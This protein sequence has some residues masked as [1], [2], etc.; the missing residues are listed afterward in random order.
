VHC[1]FLSDKLKVLAEDT[2][3]NMSLGA[4]L[5]RLGLLAAATPNPSPHDQSSKVAASRSESNDMHVKKLLGLPSKFEIDVT[6]AGKQAL[7]IRVNHCITKLICV[8]SLVPNILDSEN[9]A[10]LMAIL[11]PH[12]KVTPAEEFTSKLIPTEAARVRQLMTV[13]LQGEHNLTLTFDGNS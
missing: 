2:V 7:Q 5:E 10:E 4:K 1:K 8:N 11:N 12:Y 6:A 9:W 3:A 13:R